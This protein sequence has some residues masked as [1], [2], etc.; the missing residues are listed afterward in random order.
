MEK[1]GEL[2]ILLLMADPSDSTRLQL[3]QE[4]R[5]IRE[6]LQL[7]K[8]REKF[9]LEMRTSIRPGDLT[10]AIFDTEPQIVH[11]SG[12]GTQAGELCLENQEGRNQ[13]VSP[14]ALASLFELV[15]HQV[16][17]VLLNACYSE[18]QAKAIS[19]HIDYVIGMHQEIGDKAA[20]A[21]SIGFY[22]ALGANYSVEDA[23]KFGL[24]ELRLLSIPESLIPILV[25]KEMSA[26][27]NRKASYQSSTSTIQSPIMPPEEIKSGGINIASLQTG[28]Q[29]YRNVKIAWPDMKTACRSAETISIIGIRGLGAFGTDQS[30][31]SLAEIGDYK[32]LRKLRILL[33]SDNSRWLNPGY[34][35]LRAYESIEVF[36]KE[37]RTSHEI[38][39]SAMIK[40]SKRLKG[41]KSGIRYYSG[42]PKFG[43][44]LTDKVAF[45]NSYAE[46]SSTQVIDLPIYRFK[47][48]PGSLYAAYKRHFDDL[49]HN[50]SEPG[51]YQQK[52]IDLETSAGGIIIAEEYG[53]KYVALLRRHDGYWVLPKGHRSLSENDLEDTAIREV[54]EE[55]G[56]HRNSFYIE[57]SLGHYAYDEKAEEFNA[58]KVNHLFLMRTRDSKRPKLSPPE[59]AEAK[60]WNINTPLPEMLYTYQKSYLQEAIQLELSQ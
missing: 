46:P 8:T 60:W 40:L 7:A 47:K 10:Q 20:T 34:I 48:A 43:M 21:F 19:K 17:C 18:I 36:K 44:V 33:L 22:K 12:H 26:D 29:L 3:G 4:L 59:F 1:N 54:M 32:N 23:Y 24:V 30:L 49:W 6:K 25:T 55:T 41:T 14:E 11:F 28:Q 51:E 16:D 52:Y 39:E 45:V 37:L 13:T 9:R 53:Q 35:K 56:L 42:E 15:S 31:I 27:A 58:V 5:E 57:K 2:A 50:Q 38:V